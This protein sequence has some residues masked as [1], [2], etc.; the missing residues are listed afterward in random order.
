[1]EGEGQK[2]SKKRLPKIVI[3]GAGIAG[4]A[5]GKY[6]EL[7]GL[8]DYIILEASD[9]IGGRIW[10]VPI[11]NNGHKVEMGATWIHGVKHNPIYKLAD[12]NNLLTEMEL[13]LS[14]KNI[15]VTETGEAIHE[16]TVKKVD[17]AYGTML[18]SCEEYFLSNKTVG[19][20]ES[21]GSELARLINEKLTNTAGEE[22]HKL[23]MVYHQRQ[24]LECC[25]SGC[26][27]LYDV[28]LSQ[29]GSYKELPGSHLVIPRGFSAILDIVRDGISDEKIKLNTHVSKIHWGDVA[30]TPLGK[31]CPEEM[32]CVECENGDIYYAD[33]VIVTISLGVLK[34]TC[35]KM[36]KP[37]LPQK[38]MHAIKHLGFG[39]VNKVILIFDGTV[40]EKPTRRIHLA[41]DPAVNTTE[42]LREKWYRKIYALEVMHENVLVGWLSGKEALFLESLSD[43]EVMQDMDKVVRMFLQSQSKDIPKLTKIIRTS[44]G[45]NKYTQ[46]S[47]SFTSVG[48]TQQ[49]II[50]LKQPL[51]KNLQDNIKKP[52]VF[53]AGEA[54]H[55]CFFSTTHGALLTGNRESARICKFWKPQEA[56]SGKYADLGLSDEETNGEGETSEDEGLCFK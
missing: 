43:E 27:S 49:D 45:Q 52:V 23:E 2:K 36:F 19:V 30:N 44:W 5:A 40:V 35:D 56:A 12:E 21:L 13:N 18:S 34:A 16:G 41:W 4:L 47:Y 53:F 24:L 32:V 10:S 11:D 14:S 7:E 37:A 50:N 29:F 48:A 25:I 46:G 22:R 17:F 1:M 15:Y 20:K 28:S 54:T 38:K 9:R 51:T 31:Q 8:N 33:H 3:V 55:P 26:D 39:I 6:L 42:N